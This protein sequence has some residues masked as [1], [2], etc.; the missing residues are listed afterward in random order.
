MVPKPFMEIFPATIP[1]DRL[2]QK[3][4]LS[5]G[6]ELDITP[7]PVTG[8]YEVIRP[9]YEAAL[10]ISM[11]DLG[12]TAVAPLGRIVHARSGDKADNFN[13]G[14]WVRHED[15]YPWLKLFL[16]VDMLEELLEDDWRPNQYGRYSE[17]ERCEFPNLLAVHFRVLDFLGGGIASSSRVD[18]L[19]KG[20]GEYLRSK[21]VSIPVEFMEREPI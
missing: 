19:G 5:T 16:T 2:Q 20:I 10:P 4:V 7:A 8:E 3:V 15:E 6:G 1:L 11:A 13:V 12:P 18:G 9:S 21:L 17:V 14:L